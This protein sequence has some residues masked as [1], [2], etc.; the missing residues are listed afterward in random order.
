MLAALDALIDQ[1][2]GGRPAI[3]LRQAT[4]LLVRFGFDESADA[5]ALFDDL[6]TTLVL[7]LDA[8]SIRVLAPEL[9]RLPALLPGF[10]STVKSRFDELPPERRASARD[11]VA[12][13]ANPLT[14]ARRAHP[15]ELEEIAG[16]PSLPDTLTAIIAARGH[17]PAILLA[18]ANP[19]A[20]FRS[21]TLVM[22][23]ELAASDRALRVALGARADLPGGAFDRLWPL[24]GREARADALM[25]GTAVSVAAARKALADAD[26]A[27]RHDG[28]RPLD[29]LSA[30]VTAGDFTLSELVV[31]LA[32]EGRL[33][34]LA[35]FASGETGLSAS[36][37]FAMLCARLDHAAAVI[38]RAIGADAEALKAV[39]ALRRSRALGVG[40]DFDT[41]FE[42]LDPEEARTLAEMIDRKHGESAI[43]SAAPA[44]QG[45]SLVG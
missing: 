19:G 3:A 14:I 22:L 10:T 17:M 5:V 12:D 18:L 20:V 16:L 6:L 45:L 42:K 26:A 32:G 21:S 1:G 33:A 4:A 36:L 11:P 9:E 24:M 25:A 44:W 13:A 35:A 28:R 43:G 23:T 29:K 39:M 8:A 34:E 7:E 40:G 2:A 27:S 15:A 31:I 41:L 38:V 30:S 37:A